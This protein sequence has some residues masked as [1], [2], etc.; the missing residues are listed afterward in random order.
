MKK[1]RILFINPISGIDGFLPIGLSSLISILHDNQFIIDIFDTTYYQTNNYNDRKKN[2]LVG[3]FIP[4]DMSKFNI[5]KIQ[6]DYIR[7]LNDKIKLFNPNIIAVTIP[8]PYNYPLAI[9]LINNIEN[10]KGLILVGGKYPTVVPEKFLKHNKIDIVCIGEG[11]ESLLE[12]CNNIENKESYDTIQNLWIKKNNTIIKNSLRKLQE[13]DNLPTPNWDYFDKRHFYKP[14]AGKVYRYGHVELSRGCCFFCSYCITAKLQK[15]YKG[16][17]KYYRRKSIDK[18]IEEIK[19]LKNKY[20]LEILK[21]WDEEFLLIPLK[22]LKLFAEKYKEINLPFLI[23]ARLDSVTEEKAKIL[24]DMG[25]VNVSAGIESGNPII[26]EVILN[27]KMSNEDIIKGIE[28]LNKYGIRTSTLNIIGIPTERRKDIFETI[29]LNRIAKAQNS[30][31]M[32]LQPWEGTQI[33]EQSIRYKYMNEGDEHYTYTDSC[34]TMPQ[35]S[36]EEIKGLAKTFTL[37]RK[38]PKILY[39][40]VRL[41]EKESNFR[42]KLFLYLHKIFK[43]R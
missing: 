7:L 13:L 43:Q 32:V 16:L 26:R 2:E 41:C 23:D 42:N 36:K 28:I 40:L 37:Y 5:K 6:V 10:Y 33:R 20:N 35:L 14:F 21:F 8:T 15:I 1:T 34:L 27:R 4:V 24:K 17:G 22:E 9:E 39:P 19:Y 12:L 18:A 11:E 3:E 31:V 30:S 38:V 25:C 29:E